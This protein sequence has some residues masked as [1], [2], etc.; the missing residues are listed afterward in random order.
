[1]YYTHL[2]GN[3]EHRS[4]MGFTVCI[5][6][7]PPPRLSNTKTINKKIKNKKLPLPLPPPYNNYNI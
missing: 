5:L 2:R 4:L 7:P 3:S 6:P 1:M